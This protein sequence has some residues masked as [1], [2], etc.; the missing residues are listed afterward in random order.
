MRAFFT[1]FFRKKRKARRK[2]AA[3]DYPDL[4]K[5]DGKEHSKGFRTGK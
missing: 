4:S 1:P 2:K 3:R 5:N